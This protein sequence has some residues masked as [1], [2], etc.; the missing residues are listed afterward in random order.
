MRWLGQGI[1]QKSLVSANYAC[2]MGRGQ[3]Y[4]EGQLVTTG[5]GYD[6][7]PGVKVGDKFHARAG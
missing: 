3:G 4:D 6:Q 1:G 5:Q 2:V 7:G